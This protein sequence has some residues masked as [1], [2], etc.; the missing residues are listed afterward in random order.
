MVVDRLSFIGPDRNQYA[1]SVTLHIHPFLLEAPLVGRSVGIRPT[2]RKVVSQCRAVQ[3][4]LV[5]CCCHDVGMLRSSQDCRDRVGASCL[6]GSGSHLSS[7]ALEA[8]NSLL[9]PLSSHL[10]D[11][12]SMRICLMVMLE[13]GKENG[14]RRGTN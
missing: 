3:V 13:R 12:L 7:L 4:D 11:L 10:G 8:T 14:Q 6:F 5:G 9:S 2:G 1:R